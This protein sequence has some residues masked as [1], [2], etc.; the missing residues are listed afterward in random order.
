MSH[1]SKR[2][3]LSY[4]FDWIVIIL[5]AGVGAGFSRISPNHRPF[6]LTD[7]D[8]SFPYVEHEKVSSAVLVV[9]GLV[10]PAVIIFAVSLLF[11]P[12]PTIRKG[13]PRA[14]VFKSK[15]W[16]WN[17][18]WLGLALALA[19][20][21][22]FTEGM[23]NLY[24]KPRPDLL[25][26]C[27][28]DLGAQLTHKLG[29]FESVNN[30]ILLVSSTICRQ[31]DKS[32]LDDGFASFPSGHSSFSWAGMTYLTLF[33][34]SKFAIAIPY[35]L[36]T[37]YSTHDPAFAPSEPNPNGFNHKDET[38]P[39]ASS[40]QFRSFSSNTVK[41]LL[42]NQAAAP[43]AYLLVLA[44]FPLC[45]AVYIS[46]TRYSDF[47]HHGFDIIVGSLMGILAAWAGFRWYHLPVRRGAGWSWGPRS[48][49]RA[50]GV[51]VGVQGYVDEEEDWKSRQKDLEL[52]ER[53]GAASGG[54]NAVE[55]RA[56]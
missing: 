29:G 8:I 14:A 39:S 22:F 52:G 51:G 4:V 42:R 28:P 35:L 32:K 47:R 15:L 44:I 34:C 20:A 12:G 7:P 54:G 18:G 36:P 27:D 11:V 56:V 55:S 3:V 16:E 40:P 46:A 31:T 38:T 50:W 25:S 45:I 53:A 33:I 19:S 17:T 49:G 48:A 43:P 41:P 26:R 5:I 2:L 23:K 6:S 24:G 1:I 37:A 9:V 10:A 30:A 21:F 13:T